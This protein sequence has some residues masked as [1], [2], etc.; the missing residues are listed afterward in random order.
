[1]I[2]DDPALNMRYPHRVCSL[3]PDSADICRYVR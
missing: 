1:M 2:T 3:R